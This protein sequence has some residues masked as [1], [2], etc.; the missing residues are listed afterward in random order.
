[1]WK[2][3]REKQAYRAYLIDSKVHVVNMGP[4][5]V[6]SVPGGPHV[7]PMSFAIRVITSHIIMG[8]VI[9]SRC[10]RYMLLASKSAC[11]HCCLNVGVH[12]GVWLCPWLFLVVVLD[13]CVLVAGQ[14]PLCADHPKSDG[15]QQSTDHRQTKRPGQAGETTFSEEPAL[16]TI[17]DE[18]VRH[19]QHEVSKGWEKKYRNVSNIGSTKS[20]NLKDLLQLPLPN[21]LKAGVKPRMK[22]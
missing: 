21:P 18:Y 13:P 15:V 8:G 22:M 5:W 3:W 11:V 7:G 12:K 19:H 2:L 6:L 20:Q 1:M 9:I 14:M 4:T 10:P 17:L 16:V